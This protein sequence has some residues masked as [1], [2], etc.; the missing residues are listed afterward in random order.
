[1][2]NKRSSWGSNIGFLLAAIGSAVGLGNIWGFPY[3]MGKSG[4]FSFLIVYL[5]LAVFVGMIIMVSELALGRKTG[6]GVV[7]AYQ[8]ASKKFKWVGW[9]GILAPFLI[10]S[11]YS[12][13]GGYCI[14]YMSLNL[15]ELSF[16]LSTIFG[17]SIS[18]STTFGAMLTNPFGCFVFT[19][20][21]MVICM[22]IV[23]GGVDS[24]IEK[25][26]KVG[27][28]ALFVMLIVIIIRALTLPGSVE[29][30]KFMFV[31][32]YA[33]KAGFISEAPSIV[34]VLGTAGGQMFFSLSLA[35]G[36][37][38][39][40][41]SYLS[42]EENLV[43]NSAVIVI[44]DTVVALMAGLAVIP[45][46][47]ANGLSSGMAP[48]EIALG[49]PKLLF[50][51]LQ[52]VFANMGHAGPLFGVIFYLLVLLA[53][54]SSA[55][56]LME[57]VAAYFLDKA[58][59]KGKV[60]NRKKVVLWV[61]IAILIEALLV[62]VCGLG[63]NGIA[64]AD[65]FGW[66]DGAMYAMWNDCWLDFMDFWA[67]GIAMPLGAML[68]ALMIGGE[69]KPDYILDEVHSGEHSKFFDS[70]YKICV[71]FVVP[72]VMAFVLA[73][74]LIDNLTSY[75]V[76]NGSTIQLVCYCVSAALLVIFAIVAYTGNKKTKVR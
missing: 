72:V 39:T 44:A 17:S 34:S 30:L 20:L 28:P 61:S 23:Q 31:P 58:A 7:G 60:G 14:Q 6:I 47:V 75:N 43:K 35:M 36:A 64:P 9:L 26:N 41:G 70:F 51:T 12:V 66:K 37:M 40:Y 53:A 16:G 25:F 46:A 68:M 73:G 55:I 33:V 4:G 45:A 67:E 50:V 11:F 19:L 59:E 10:M 69:M 1:M 74:M 27:M 24:G 18:G 48:S 54:I 56:S 22:L 8:K 52:D 63:E 13:L 32:G 71:T 15:A 29:G 42:K 49:G 57:V 65:L 2:E 62:A 3:K 76:N 5:L 21:F 38:V